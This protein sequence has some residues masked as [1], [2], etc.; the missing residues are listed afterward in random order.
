MFMANRIAILDWGIRIS[1]LDVP[2]KGI[3]DFLRSVD[4]ADI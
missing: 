1:D 4:V 3:A 2:R